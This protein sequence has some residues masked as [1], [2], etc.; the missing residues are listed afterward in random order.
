MLRLNHL[1]WVTHM[2]YQALFGF[3]KLGQILGRAITVTIF[4]LQITFVVGFAAGVYADQN[5]EVFCFHS[6]KGRQ[7]YQ[8]EVAPPLNLL[9][10]MGTIHLS[11][12]ILL[13]DYIWANFVCI[14][15]S[16]LS[17]SFT[18]RLSELIFT[19]KVLCD[20]TRLL[21]FCIERGTI[22]VR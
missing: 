2:K 10:C 16:G 1:S 18:I 14:C 7:P 11:G 21:K 6:V 22:H 4:L 15:L 12:T 8:V 9:T 19:Q 13:S 5:F 3:S 20:Q 17:T